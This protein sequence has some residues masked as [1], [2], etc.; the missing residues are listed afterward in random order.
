MNRE[1][2][3]ASLFP[4]RGDVSAEAG[5]TTATVVGIQTVPVD[6]PIYPTDDMYVA[7]YIAADDRI[8]W[9]LGFS[10]TLVSLIPGD[11]LV[12][13]GTEW[14]NAALPEGG[15]FL[16]NNGV[17]NGSQIVLDLL[18]GAG[19]SITDNGVGGIT[20]SA[21][22]G[23]SGT[24]T[25]VSTG[26][27]LTGG[28]ITTS[29]TVSLAN[30]AVTPGSYTNTNL[31][32]D[33]QGRITAAANGSGGSGIDLQTN[34][35]DNGS[36][37]KLNLIAGTNISITDGGTGGV[38]I[39]ASGGGGDTPS[40]L[41]GFG[42]LNTSA[43][44]VGAAGPSSGY[45]DTTS[46][47]DYV[48]AITGSPSTWSISAKFNWAS[49]HGDATDVVVGIVLWQQSGNLRKIFF[50]DQNITAYLQNY[51]G[52]SLTSTPFNANWFGVQWLKVSADGTNFY[53]QIS[54]D[55]V[56]WKTIYTEAY[57]T[58]CTPD[59]YG[60]LISPQSGV[61]LLATVFNVAKTP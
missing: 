15:I 8:E 11:I 55:G 45:T 23:G 48:I 59:H 6:M 17:P 41:S 26:T 5:A 57:G 3:P 9:R 39:A 1:I 40:D 43:G 14:I 60:F 42:V 49:A 12:W 32:V 58:F 19:I 7:T 31:T 29:G 27:G 38:T 47:V 35:V 37:S 24:V 25:L 10:P 61:E 33:Q 16:E 34:G 13:N 36:Q 28:P 2:F 53:Y 56:S 30:T 22:G 50:I 51:T 46:D 44:T 21:T 20:I 54:P 4:L 18:A 52:A